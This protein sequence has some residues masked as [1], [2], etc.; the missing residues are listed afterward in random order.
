GILIA[1]NRIESAYLEPGATLQLGLSTIRFEHGDAQVEEP[2]SEDDR[3]GRTIGRSV[4]MRRVF[5]SLP[6]IAVSEA[7]VLL[8][9]ETGTGK[10]VGGRDDIKVDI[11]VIAATNQDLRGAVN[12]GDFRA[13][14]YYRLHVVSLRLPPLRERRDDIPLLVES[15]YEQFAGL[16]GAPQE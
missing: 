10:R 9:G 4:A 2:L 1:G 5:E 15:F 16:P 6:K 14:L 3:F 12:R 13:D 7:T 8:E 11:R